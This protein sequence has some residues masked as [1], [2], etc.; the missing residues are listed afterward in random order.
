MLSITRIDCL[1][2]FLSAVEMP[3]RGIRP[4]LLPLPAICTDSR[5]R[6]FY[7][8][9]KFA[10]QTGFDIIE[11]NRTEKYDEVQ[12]M[13]Y[14][15]LMAGLGRKGPGHLYLLTGEE[16]YYIDK[17]RER[18]L[19]LLHCSR[20]EVQLFEEGAAA[21]E[22][23]AAIETV[24]FLV[25]K[26]VIIVRA[27]ALFKDRKA[28]GEKAG[29]SGHRRA[30][31]R[32]PELLQRLPDFSYVIFEYH[33][34]ADKRKKLYKAIQEHGQ[35][36]DAEPVRANNIGDWLQG[37]LQELNKEMDRHAYEYFVGAV[38]TMQPVNLS[39]LN[40]E[41][42]KL[43][44]FLGPEQRRITREHLLQVFSEVPE[45]SSFAMLNA[46]AA[47]QTDRALQLFR[48]QLANGVYFALLAG[49]L[50]RQVRLWWQAQAL[51]S[52]G[53]QGRA[54]A[55]A[56]GQPPFIA[57]KTGREARSFPAGLLKSVLLALSD[58]D[59]GL[60]TGR[61]DVVELEAAIIQL[62]TRGAGGF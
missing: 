11:V 36:M 42:D 45:I 9:K 30:E 33:G 19:G 14:G 35:I 60:K 28:E 57:E 38:S 16:S 20:D 53:V 3:E 48:R 12:G 55:G 31:D 51:Q 1:R 44:L 50:A 54:L 25:E 58:A 37:R 52:R 49:M 26:N 24:P 59:Y 13:K 62:S 10:N 32:L 5:Q 21:S 29:I 17:A 61:G 7:V 4:V 43:A 27:G 34:R 8:E 6:C 41:L 56:L 2:Q 18:L 23:I 46:I 40:R 22:I 15:E 39:F 47:R